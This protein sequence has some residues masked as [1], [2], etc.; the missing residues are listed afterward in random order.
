MLNILTKTLVCGYL[1][2]GADFWGSYVC[3]VLVMSLVFL[4][5]LIKFQHTE[6]AYLMRPVETCTFENTNRQQT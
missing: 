1:V 5:E 6:K 4:F 3:A 2:Q